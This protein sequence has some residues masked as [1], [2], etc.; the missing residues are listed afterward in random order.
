[1][2][3]IFRR[4]ATT[5]DLSNLTG[6]APTK[7]QRF[8]ISNVNHVD[9]VFEARDQRVPVL[10]DSLQKDAA[11]CRS[12]NIRFFLSEIT[13]ANSVWM[14]KVINEWIWGGLQWNGVCLN[15]GSVS[16]V[17]AASRRSFIDRVE[18]T[19]LGRG[20]DKLGGKRRGQQISDSKRK[21]RW[22]KFCHLIGLRDK[23]KG[24]NRKQYLTL[25]MRYL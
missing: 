23:G 18:R 10:I 24:Q 3:I 25:S 4:T 12:E 1:M 5:F 6:I 16:N 11:L 2:D 13:D 17:N 22:E 14:R 21:T 15:V 20:I 7:Q 19:I 8:R 9:F